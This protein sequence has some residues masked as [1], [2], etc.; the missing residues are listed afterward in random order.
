MK[1]MT[2]AAP[3][4]TEQ[5]SPLADTPKKAEHLSMA[6]PAFPPIKDPFFWVASYLADLAEKVALEHL[7]Q[8]IRPQLDNVTIRGLFGADHLYQQAL[9]ECVERIREKGLLLY[10][11]SGTKS[12]THLPARY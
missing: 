1:S 12:F 7:R 9:N 4:T 10:A 5:K 6:Y 11:W 2:M 8:R 3:A